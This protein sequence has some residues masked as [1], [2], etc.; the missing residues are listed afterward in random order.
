VALVLSPR[1]GAVVP[2]HQGLVMRRFAVFFVIGVML[3]IFADRCNST[4]PPSSPSIKVARVPEPPPVEDRPYLP[5][6][7]LRA[8]RLA[9]DVQRAAG[10]LDTAAAPQIDLIDRVQ[11]A[12]AEHGG[13]TE[14]NRLMTQQRALRAI[15]LDAAT[16]LQSEL[17]DYA[18]VLRRCEEEIN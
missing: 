6:Q 15:T 3:G 17:Y 14:L 8:V 11:R 10:V 18:G 7:C 12:I 9:L 16:K 4:P 5:E 1:A 13:I 2:P